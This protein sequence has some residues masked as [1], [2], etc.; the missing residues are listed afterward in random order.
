VAISNHR[1]TAVNKS[2]VSFTYKDYRDA[3]K[4]KSVDL[5]GTEFLRRFATHILPSGFIRIRHYG[6]L[7]SK[8]KATELNIAKVELKQ[9]IWEKQKYSWIEI[10]QQKLNYNPLAC[11]H[12]GAEQII[13]MKTILPERGPPSENEKI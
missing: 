13:T 11:H 3:A 10:C 4:Q 7:A 9:P 6:F 5:Q 2:S 1:L 8:N 12:C